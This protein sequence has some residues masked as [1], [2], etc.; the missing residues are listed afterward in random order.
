M[1]KYNMSSLRG[2]GAPGRVRKLST[3]LEEIKTLKKSLTLTGIKGV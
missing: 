2:K 3:H 1:E